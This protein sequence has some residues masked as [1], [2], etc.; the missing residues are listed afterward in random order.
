MILVYLSLYV[1][2][3]VLERKEMQCVC[4]FKCV[5]VHLSVS[6]FAFK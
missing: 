6:L 4:V 2:V 3:S 1:H 5:Y